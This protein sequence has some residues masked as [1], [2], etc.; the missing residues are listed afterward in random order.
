[1]GLDYLTLRIE[2]DIN[3]GTFK[4][5]S[6]IKKE[7]YADLINSFVCTQIGKGEDKKEADKRDIYDISIKWYPGSDTFVCYSNTG[8]KG[9]REGILMDVSRKIDTPYNKSKD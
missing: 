6:N 4:I 3:D 1:M 8:N 9:L 5:A 2:Y 7:R